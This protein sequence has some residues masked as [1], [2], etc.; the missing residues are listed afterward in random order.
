MRLRV[1]KPCDALAIARLYLDASARLGNAYVAQL[2]LGFLR[3][4]Y[5]M[6]MS[7]RNGIVLCLEN[8][9]GEI[10]GFVS[11][12]LHIEE[13]F[14]NLSRKRWQ[15]AMACCS[16]FLR[17]PSLLRGAIQRFRTMR[18][19]GSRGRFI[20]LSGPRL[21]FWACKKSV[22]GVDSICLVKAWL[23][24][25]K[26]AGCQMVN[27]EVDEENQRVLQVHQA[28]GAG[29]IE[30]FVTGDGRARCVLTYTF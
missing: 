10:V 25:A 22:S 18:G 4:N 12:S 5:K 13:H 1:A 27:C 29:I 23:S 15:L 24:L 21:E 30:R 11:G 26:F 20:V 6:L 28:L 19:S 16:A 17:H 7:E 14:E 9:E 3:L 2:G 8:G